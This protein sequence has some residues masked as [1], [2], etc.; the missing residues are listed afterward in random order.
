M[1]V[2][3]DIGEVIFFVVVDVFSRE[4]QIL[5]VEVFGI[6]FGFFYQQFGI[7]IFL[8]RFFDKYGVDLRVQVFFIDEV[9]GDEIGIV[10]DFI[11]FY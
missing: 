10:N 1:I 3:F 9:I 8:M 7:G 2:L 11:F 4:I 6:I 5:V